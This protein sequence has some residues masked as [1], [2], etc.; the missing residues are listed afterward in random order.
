MLPDPLLGELPLPRGTEL[1]LGQAS[2]DP[3]G[4]MQVIV[5]GIPQSCRYLDPTVLADGDPVLVAFMSGA[6][7][8]SQA[9]VLGRTTARPRPGDGSVTAVPGGSST[10]TVATS[11][12]NVAARFVA[13][14][15][16]VVGD[17]VIIDWQSALPTVTGKVGATAAPA[18]PPRPP[19]TPPTGP[20]SG[21]RTFAAIDSATA[22]AGGGWN[23]P[24][25]QNLTQGSWGGVAYA[26]AW[27]YGTAPSSL[28]GRTI[29]GAR[30]LVG[31]RR[32]IGTY[33]ATILL[34][35]YAHNST[36]RPGGDVNRVTGP[37]TIQ[38]APNDPGGWVNIPIAFAQQ[39]VAGGG[40]GI[41]GNP[42]AGVQGRGENPA[43]GTLAIDWRA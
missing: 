8:Q 32:R 7:G 10:I 35:L 19:I 1:K 21:T 43:S 13:S 26:G 38:L 12:G 27:F 30:L 28:A 2:I 37:F 16:P 5:G 31:A 9:V 39:V 40:I 6:I 17:L 42:Y 4:V 11:E 14:Y 29:T 24:S 20:V 34:N 15:T 33:N 23:S 25:G 41:F 36:A 3:G 22:R 18:P